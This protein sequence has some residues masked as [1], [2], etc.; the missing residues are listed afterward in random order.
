MNSINEI[1]EWIDA[2]VREGAAYDQTPTLRQCM[3]VGSAHAGMSVLDESGI[4]HRAG[5][6]RYEQAFLAALPDLLRSGCIEPTFA[7]GQQQAA[8]TLWAAGDPLDPRTRGEVLDIPLRARERAGPPEDTRTSAQRAGDHLLGLL[9]SEGRV[10][11]SRF[12][13]GS[14]EAARRLREVCGCT[15]DIVSAELLMDIAAGQLEEQGVA[16]LVTLHNR[17]ADGENDYAIELTDEGKALL[18]SGRQVRFRDV[19]R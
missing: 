11:Y 4:E 19:I 5:S 16:R 7:G 14:D 8:W 6:P 18:E 15:S 9:K 12:Y 13:D 2:F 17:L 10:C 1:A 3:D